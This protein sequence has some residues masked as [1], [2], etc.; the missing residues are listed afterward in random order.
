MQAPHV[1][2]AKIPAAKG[3]LVDILCLLCDR[4]PKHFHHVLPR[5]VVLACSELAV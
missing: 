5:L 1:K 2:K 3:P 4:N